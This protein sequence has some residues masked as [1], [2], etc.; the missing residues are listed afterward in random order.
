MALICRTGTRLL[1]LPLTHVAETLR[2][3][4][5]EPLVG[6]PAFVL[7]LSILRGAPVPVVDAGILLGV[8]EAASPTRLVTLRT[9]ERQVALAVEE[10]LGIR[11][12]PPAHLL[13][14][15]PLLEGSADGAVAAVGAL[16]TKL[17]LVLRAARLLP[18]AAWQTIKAEGSGAKP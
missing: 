11:A 3:L 9:G 10:V 4:P 16:D 12:L 2:V 13:E 18:E 7:G 5:I 15:P 1:A 17:L 6:S 8:K 14:M